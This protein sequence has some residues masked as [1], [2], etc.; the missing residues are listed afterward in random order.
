MI[1]QSNENSR[2]N[3]YAVTFYYEQ[4]KNIKKLH[5]IRIIIT[6]ETVIFK[7][8]QV[9]RFQHYNIVMLVSKV[10][11]SDKWKQQETL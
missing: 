2:I 5:F 11:Y 8:F 1:I 9:L 10:F 7:T 6:K 3:I 4:N